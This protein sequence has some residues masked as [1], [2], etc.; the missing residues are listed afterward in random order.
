MERDQG[1]FR[2]VIWREESEGR[3]DVMRLHHNHKNKRKMS[4]QILEKAKLLTAF[5]L[6]PHFTLGNISST[7]KCPKCCNVLCETYA[8][9]SFSML[10][11]DKMI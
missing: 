1:G 4:I 2:G 3:N 8:L 6:E 5:E 11:N 7:R 9:M 10:S